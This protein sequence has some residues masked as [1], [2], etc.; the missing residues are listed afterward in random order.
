[1]GH[2]GGTLLALTRG[3]SFNPAAPSPFPAFGW[4]GRGER[5]VAETVLDFSDSL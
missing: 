4:P 5:K 1:M 2:S 3:A